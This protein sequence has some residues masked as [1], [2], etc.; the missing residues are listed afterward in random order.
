[1]IFG[2]ALLKGSSD[3]I[4]AS[5]RCSESF[6][7]EEKYSRTSKPTLPFTAAS[8]FVSADSLAL[9]DALA[10]VFAEAFA[11]PLGF[12]AGPGFWA[13]DVIAGSVPA[14]SSRSILY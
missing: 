13:G 6:S 8:G 12:S 9:L 14:S 5:Q 4:R 7:W 11:F 2:D 10:A 3:G 1:M